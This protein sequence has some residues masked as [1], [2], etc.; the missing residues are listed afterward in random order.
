[1]AAIVYNCCLYPISDLMIYSN[2]LKQLAIDYRNGQVNLSNMVKYKPPIYLKL[3]EETSFLP[4]KPTTAQRL[5]HV[6]NDIFEIPMC[7]ACSN[8]VRWHTTHKPVAKYADYCSSKCAGS[9]LA[10]K[11]KR[12]ATCMS[13]YGVDS[14]SKT[15]THKDSS[16]NR[17]P[18]TVMQ[19]SI[20][21][22][23]TVIEKYGVD[24]LNKIPGSKE[25]RQ[26]TNLDRYGST[27]ILTSDYVKQIKI[28]RYGTADYV[29]TNEFRVK[30]KATMLKNHG[31]EYS[32]QSSK[33]LD[34]SKQTNLDRYGSTSWSNHHISKQS[35]DKLNDVDWLID[36]HITQQKPSTII[37]A[38]LGVDKETVSNYMK[39]VG[40]NRV[41]HNASYPETQLAQWLTDHNIEFE[42]NNRKLLRG[43][44][45]DIF[46]PSKNI[47][48]EYCGLYWH[49][50]AM[51]PNVRNKH[52]QKLNA[53][54]KLGIRLITLFEDEWIHNQDLVLD[55]ISNILH[56]SVNDRVYA[57]KCVI[58]DVTSE[59]KSTFFDKYHIQGNGP[60]SINI[61]L[62]FDGTLVACMGFIKQK[63]DVCIL[64]RYA[65]NIN[66]VG[67][68]SR[69]L[70]H[71]KADYAWKEIVSFADRRWS[72]GSVYET[73][74]FKCDQILPPDYD[75][76]DTTTQKRIH[77]FNF[78]RKNLSKIIG[79]QFNP[80]LS[81]TENTQAAGWYRI[82]NCGLL[83]YTLSK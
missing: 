16:S 45:L 26:Q 63:H 58:K 7:K 70:S 23:N 61:G 83:R 72:T 79:D 76:I 29:T 53:C 24:A 60:S 46:I 27:N 69:L 31:V 40:L 67:G 15:P 78:R 39:K 50:T 35:L 17:D 25:K 5:Y 30:S 66:V 42:V 38:E 56:I 9:S 77:K 65:T 22:K 28:D 62:Y 59:D 49:S 2:D 75:Y 80:L 20:K 11:T 73:N 43:K 34:K 36:Q 18:N 71:F 8:T 47:A 1:M 14:Y 82:Y 52:I 54:S 44:E 51:N 74:G 19:A 32:G 57:R 3:V 81:E 33:L 64:N 41:R 4:D 48:I 68:F 10:A 13:K 55:K 37:A 21:R 6:H 12:K